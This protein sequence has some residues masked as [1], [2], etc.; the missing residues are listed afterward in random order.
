MAEIF[1]FDAF[2]PAEIAERVESVGVK[3]ARLPLLQ[4]FTLGVLAGGFIGLGALY[5]TLVASDARLGFSTG[6]LLG[7]LAM[8]LGM[9]RMNAPGPST[10]EE[11]R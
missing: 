2:S 9:L 3:K 7:G 11:T 6:R 10:S 8:I 4:M 5:F 1:G